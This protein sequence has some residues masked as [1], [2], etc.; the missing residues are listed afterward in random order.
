MAKHII[1]LSYAPYDTMLHQ[2]NI[3]TIQLQRNVNDKHLM[4]VS[5][6]KRPKGLNAHLSIRDSTLTSCQNG[7]YLN[8]RCPRINKKIY[9]L[10]LSDLF[11]GLEKK[12]FKNI[13][14]FH[15]ITYIATA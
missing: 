2:K 1:G 4:T 11:L 15:F 12:I 9:T 3:G 13:M 14:Y 8:I 7:S 6:N 5:G 10:S